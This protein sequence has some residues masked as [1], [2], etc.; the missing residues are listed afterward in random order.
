M[1]VLFATSNP[2]K[3]KRF[4][5]IKSYGIEILSLNDLNI[6]ID[7]EENGKD[8]IENALIKARCAYKKVNIPVISMDDGLY[9]EGV[10]NKLQPGLYVRRIKNKTLTDEEMID[11]YINLVNQYGLNGKLNAKWRYGIVIIKNNQEYAFT[12]EKDGFYLTNKK[13]DI[14]HKGY[15]LDSISIDKKTNKYLVDNNFEYSNQDD[16]DALNF[17]INKLVD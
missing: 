7:V 14:I 1:K 4:E 12:Y 16:Q 3:I 8:Q 2:S 15:P 13:S 9:L 10:P 6:K 5:S 17:L 11:Y